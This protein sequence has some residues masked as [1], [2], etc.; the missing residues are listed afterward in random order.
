MSDPD[1]GKDPKRLRDVLVRLRPDQVEYLIQSG[2][3]YKKVR[4]AVDLLMGV[5]GE[6][7]EHEGHRRTH[8]P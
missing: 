6:R 2:D 7:E 8:S 3:F 5:E 1:V 4:E